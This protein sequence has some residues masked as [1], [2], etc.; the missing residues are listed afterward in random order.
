MRN[1]IVPLAAPLLLAFASFQAR[2][3]LSSYSQDFELLDQTGATALGD[4]DWLVYGNVFATNGTTYLY[5][6]GPF[7]APNDGFAFSQIDLLQ[8]GVEQGLQQLVVFSDY[9]NTD[10]ALGRIIESNV[11]HEQTIAAENVG[12]TWNFSFQ[13]KLGNLT[14]SSTATAFIKTLNPAAGY[15]LT[16]FLAEDMTAIPTSWGGWT[17]SISIDAGLVGQLL[18]FGFL[19]RATTYQGSGIFYD[20]IEFQQGPPTDTPAAAQLGLAQN[21]PNPF[22]PFTRIEFSLPSAQS[23]SLAIFDLAGRHVVTLQRGFLPEGPHTVSWDGRDATGA[24]VAS[25]RYDY[26]LRSSQ[27]ELTRSMVLIK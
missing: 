9:N 14:G 5:G 26:V 25:G 4:D 11:F 2:A 24:R 27:G 6:Y 23:V 1:R 16:N 12:Q 8:G 22:N 7:P 21:Y 10:H 19:N 15:A 13:A 18:Q 17:I 3:A 20:N